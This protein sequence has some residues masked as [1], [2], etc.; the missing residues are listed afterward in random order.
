MF[1]AL[2]LMDTMSLMFV[3]WL[4]VSDSLFVGRRRNWDAGSKLYRD[5]VFNCVHSKTHICVRFTFN[6]PI[7]ETTKGLKNHSKAL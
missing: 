3:A 5:I 2:K 6:M 7:L 4:V 1:P